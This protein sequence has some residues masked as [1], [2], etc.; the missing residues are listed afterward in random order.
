MA[1][2]T[3]F[4]GWH[5]VP[6]P[7]YR[8]QTKQ[9]KAAHEVDNLEQAQ[10]AVLA[11]HKRHDDEL[12]ARGM[13]QNIYIMPAEIWLRLMTVQDVAVHRG[14]HPRTTFYHEQGLRRLTLR[15]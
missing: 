15:R 10:M 3:H 5:I 7:H 13:P 9:P 6:H 1:Q 4:R 11:W 8:D 14:R 2:W 12:R